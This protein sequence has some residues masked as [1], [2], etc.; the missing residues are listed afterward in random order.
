MKLRWLAAIAFVGVLVA[1]CKTPS[2]KV[3][4]CCGGFDRATRTTPS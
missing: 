1:A 2:A 3:G 4:G